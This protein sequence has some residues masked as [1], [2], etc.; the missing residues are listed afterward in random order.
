MA[1]ME[2]GGEQT[3]SQNK[4]ASLAEYVASIFSQRVVSASLTFGIPHEV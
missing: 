3:F 2:E 4:I 1:M